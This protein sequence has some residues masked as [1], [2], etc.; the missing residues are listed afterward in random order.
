LTFFHFFQA[1]NRSFAASKNEKMITVEN[2][3]VEFSGSVLF[4]EVSF[5]INPTDKNCPDG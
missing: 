1:Y 4:S 3:A 5:V 2:L